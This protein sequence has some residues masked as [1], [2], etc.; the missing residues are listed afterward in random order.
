VTERIPGNFTGGC[1][2][3][4]IRY[5][6][7]ERR[8]DAHICHCRMC[9]KAVGGYMAAFVGLPQDKFNWARGTPSV[10]M[11]SDTT[12]RGFCSNCGTPLYCRWIQED[13]YEINIAT[14]DHADSVAPQRQIGNESRVAYFDALHML[15]GRDTTTE[16]SMPDMAKTIASSN[17]QHPDEETM[18]WIPRPRER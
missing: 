4:A 6:A 11:S 17:H 7:T 9:Q 18:D 2:C 13:Y 1:Q 16:G 8:D 5:S 14:L 15:S 12:E 10:F 3:G